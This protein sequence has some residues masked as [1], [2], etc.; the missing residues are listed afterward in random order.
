MNQRII[1]ILAMTALAMPWTLAAA[2][3]ESTGAAP[4]TASE[5]Y[6]RMLEDAE[7]ARIEAEAARHE[8]ER[9]V[10]RARETARLQAE[11]RQLEAERASIDAEQVAREHQLRED[12]MERV[13]EELSRTHRELREASREVA[14]AHRELAR[15]ERDQATRLPNLGDR[16]VIG[17]VLG[18]PGPKGIELIG[19]S[20]GGPAEAAGL[21]VGD[22]IAEIAGEDL[23][24]QP[25]QAR[26]RLFEVMDNVEAGD[27][28]TVVVD[29]DG[30]N[31]TFTVTAEV[32]EPSSWQSIIT[33]PEVA[34]IDLSDVAREAEIIVE[35]IRV[36]EVDEAA[37]QQKMQE[38]QERLEQQK[39]IFIDPDGSQ[40]IGTGDFEFDIENFSGFADQAFADAD[41]FFGLSTTRGLEFAT[42]N[43]DLGAYFKTERGV[44]V[45]RAAEDNAYQLQAGDVILAVDGEAVDTPAELLRVLRRAE[46]GTEL[47]LDIKRD[48]RSR[49]LDVTM[50]ENRLGQR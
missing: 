43:E 27:E 29:R 11:R 5:A 40:H 32:R 21:Q 20:P 26:G 38:L 17:V 3:P 39:F 18:R 23:S 28:V 37:L 10:E 42:I 48:R 50:P 12:E 46:P 7:R 9:L 45:L 4:D 33:V 34:D 1:L 47:R 22:V 14:R 2:E 44:L 24:A 49:T 41:V 16:A 13:R 25:E 6:Q 35:R 15:A 19:V 8:A 36:P 30:T 31:E